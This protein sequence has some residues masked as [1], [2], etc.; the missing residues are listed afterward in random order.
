[1]INENNGKRGFAPGIDKTDPY[2]IPHCRY[3]ALKNYCSKYQFWKYAYDNFDDLYFA[4]KY[5]NSEVE[6]NPAYCNPTEDKIVLKSEYAKRVKFIDDS[7]YEAD[8]EIWRFIVDSVSK[9]LSY[10]YL[11]YQCKML[12]TKDEFFAAKKRFFWILSNTL[13]IKDAEE[14]ESMTRKQAL[15]DKTKYLKQGRS[16]I[17]KNPGRKHYD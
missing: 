15:D 17:K 12:R 7:A 10:E 9:N 2:I 13:D 1:M 6:C 4:R 8:P 3:L 16:Y 11:R 14:I 5:V